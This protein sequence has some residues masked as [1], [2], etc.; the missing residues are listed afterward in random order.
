M[1]DETYMKKYNVALK[2]VNKLLTNMGKDNID[3]LEDFKDIDRDQIDTLQ[4][5]DTIEAMENE[6][7]KVFDKTKCGYYDKKRVSAYPMRLLRGVASQLDIEFSY[8]KNEEYIS[9]NNKRYHRTQL[10]YSFVKNI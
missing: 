8:R 7:Y 6:I 9:L 4:N 3:A 1:S 5:K 2:L 10:L